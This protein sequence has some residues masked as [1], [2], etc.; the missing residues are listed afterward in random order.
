MRSRCSSVGIKAGYGLDGWDLISG[1]G[2]RLFLPHRNQTGPGAHQASYPMGTRVCGF[3]GKADQSPS[4]AEVR[5]D[6][7]VLHSPIRL[8]GVVRN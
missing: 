5:N 2:K 3:E 4:R 1:R 8:Q 6:G 7:A